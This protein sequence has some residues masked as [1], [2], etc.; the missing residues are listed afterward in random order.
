MQQRGS[1][2]ISIISYLRKNISNKTSV[3]LINKTKKNK[4]N[5]KLHLVDVML[6]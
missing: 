1:V 2:I 5:E 6:Y 3:K 4:S